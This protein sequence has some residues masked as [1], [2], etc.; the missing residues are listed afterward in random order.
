[1]ALPKL[2]IKV[3]AD[4][5]FLEDIRT[6]NEHPLVQGFTTN[7]TLM[8]Q[9]GVTD[10]EGF[11][12]QVLETITDKPISFEVFADDL[13]TM[14][15]QARK[16]A[17]WASN[18]NVKIPVTTTQGEFTGPILERL[19]AEGVCLNVTA[20]FTLDQVTRIMAKLDP[21]TPSIISIFAG[22]IADTGKDPIP[23]MVQAA[24]LLRSFPKADL[25]WASPREVLNIY[26][27]DAAGCQIITVTKDLLKKLEFFQKDLEEFSLDTVKMFYKD[28][29]SAGY[30]IE[31][32]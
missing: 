26:Q 7:P 11:A 5:A 16:I 10:Y 1:M 14:Y 12:H 19:S 31:L 3:F 21:Q 8:R 9:A 20:V 4:G 30:R 13:D 23:H 17:S 18:V 6:L 29:T 32:D 28:A 22:R 25:L 2:G 15:S 24:E 27:A